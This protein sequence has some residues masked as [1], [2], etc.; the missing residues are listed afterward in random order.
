[1]LSD[2]SIYLKYQN[3]LRNR[4]VENL[5]AKTEITYW[6]FLRIIESVRLEN[7]LSLSLEKYIVFFPSP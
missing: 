1:M 3:C 5:E 4:T 7:T 6:I 2:S